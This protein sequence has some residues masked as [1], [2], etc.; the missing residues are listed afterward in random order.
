[1]SILTIPPS[2]LVK[3]ILGPDASRG[4]QVLDRRPSSQSLHV[5]ARE[6]AE[7]TGPLARADIPSVVA[8]LHYVHC[9]TLLQLQFVIVLWLVIVQRPVSVGIQVPVSSTILLAITN[10]D[11][12]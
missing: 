7:V 5:V 4:I 11:K 6:G 1:M 3:T 9:V 2:T 10:V 8:L 12:L